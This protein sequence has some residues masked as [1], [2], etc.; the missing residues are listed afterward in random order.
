MF[1][2]MFFLFLEKFYKQY[3]VY[4]LKQL[5]CYLVYYY[6]LKNLDERKYIYFQKKLRLIIGK[7]IKFYYVY[8]LF[9]LFKYCIYMYL[10]VYVNKEFF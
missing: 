5:D 8:I 3:Y 2:V 1:N 10:W 9:I 7:G 6:G 4:L